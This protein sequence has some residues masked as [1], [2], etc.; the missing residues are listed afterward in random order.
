MSDLDDILDEIEKTEKEE[1]TKEII[2]KEETSLS[3][4]VTEFESLA[5]ELMKMTVEDRKKAD[6]A[7]ELFFPEIARG[8]DRSQASKEALMKSIELKIS[9]GR[10]IIDILKLLKNEEKKNGTNVGIFLNTKKSGIDLNNI[11]KDI[12]E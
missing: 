6:E 4:D 10:N 5:G 9:A 2:E 12:D 3:V 7:F 1:E 8:T 11:I